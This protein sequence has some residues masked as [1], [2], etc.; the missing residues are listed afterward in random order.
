MLRLRNL[1]E[2]LAKVI[3]ELIN[4]KDIEEVDENVQQLL[5]KA[6]VASLRLLVD[7]LLK[8]SAALMLLRQCKGILKQELLPVLLILYLL[9]DLVELR[10]GS[11]LFIG[12]GLLQLARAL[13]LLSLLA[14]QLLL[15]SVLSKFTLS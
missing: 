7:L 3:S 14:E 5:A 13:H 8:S 10:H 11:C 9:V 12:L 4:H 1:Y 2:L 15:S 6:E